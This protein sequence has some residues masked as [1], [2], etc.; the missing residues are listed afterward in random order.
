MRTASPNCAPRSTAPPAGN[1][2]TRSS[3]TRSSTRS[4]AGRT[5]L[6]SR[7]T[8]LGAHAG[9]RQSP[10]R[11][12]S[13]RARRRPPISARRASPKPS[14]ISDTVIF[15]APPDREARLESRTPPIDQRAAPNQFAKIQG[16]DNVIVRLQTLARSGRDAARS[17]RSSLVEDSF[18]SRARRMRGVLSDL[19][20]D[21]GAAGSRRAAQRHRRP[22]RA[23]QTVRQTPALSSAS[24]IGSTS[25]A[26]RS[27]A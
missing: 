15:V 25:P 8:A 16:V 14:P 19:G 22:V 24:S 11:S 9:R 20:L 21:I 10:A 6:E 26:P 23:G 5:T 27:S 4:C 2:S 7:A 1:C 18:E 3:S 12:A 13:R 17:P